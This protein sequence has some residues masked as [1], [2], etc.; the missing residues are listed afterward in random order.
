MV[1][2]SFDLNNIRIWGQLE[3]TFAK[4][5]DYTPT[6]KEWLTSS[7]NGFASPKDLATK[8]LPHLPTAVGFD[9][10]KEIGT[11]ISSYP[12]DFN[13]H[14]NLKRIIANRGKSVIE[15]TGVDM[16]TAEAL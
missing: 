8:V 12:K 7:W 14:P 16:S 15:N 3:D 2:A 11:A 13:I 5:K 10:L 1:L 4:S 6:S 9:T